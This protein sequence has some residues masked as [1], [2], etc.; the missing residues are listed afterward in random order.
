ITKTLANCPLAA[1]KSSDRK[2]LTK[3]VKSAV[4]VLVSAAQGGADSLR[5]SIRRAAAELGEL[6]PVGMLFTDGLQ[7][8]LAAAKDEQATAFAAAA[9]KCTDI[10][11]KAKMPIDLYLAD[12]A[13]CLVHGNQK[14]LDNA[15]AGAADTALARLAELATAGPAALKAGFGAWNASLPP[16]LRLPAAFATG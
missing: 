12:V 1:T 7:K 2:A 10:D 4:H 15:R 9:D 6:I 5:L 16:D 8:S 11:R 3:R 13:R 14:V